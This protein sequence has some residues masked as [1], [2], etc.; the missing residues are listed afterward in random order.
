MA[1]II[2]DEVASINTPA[3]SK[4][5]IY[6]S[7]DTAQSLLRYLDSTG[8]LTAL[9]PITNFSAAAQS[10]TAT[11]RTYLTGSAIAVPISKLQVGTILSWKF[12]MTKTAAGTAA[13]T[14][15]IAV[16]TTGSTADVARVS[17]T[18][19][20]GTAAADEGFVTIDAIVRGP[21]T[22]SGIITAEL[23]MTHNLSATGHATI[24]VV[25]VN[26][27]SAGF[28]MTV[29]NLILGVCIT[30]GASDVITIQQVTAQ[31]WNL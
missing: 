17:F 5:A 10:P 20:A 6:A 14:I 4:G 26:T 3:A 13:S 1:A 31:A 19:P 27:V 25:V 15:D 30:T 24:P 11:V 9:N 21:I 2:L 23:V 7:S 12:N 18:K 22:A 28:D 29:A 16:G 8:R